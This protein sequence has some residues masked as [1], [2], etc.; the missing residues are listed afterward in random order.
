MTRIHLISATVGAI[1]LATGALAAREVA[2]VSMPDTDTIAGRAVVLNGMGVRRRMGVAVYVAGLHVEHASADAAAILSADEVRSMRLHLVRKVGGAR[3]AEA[4]VE[5][6]ERNSRADMPRPRERLAQ[7]V[8]MLPD[9]AAGDEI[10]LT[11]VPGTGT[12]VIVRGA[13]RGTIPG[14]DF[15]DALLAVWLGADPVQ[16]ELKRALLGR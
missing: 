8:A 11:C 3:M 14:R 15:A 9:V 12:L 4:I 5:G 7:F 1:A 10:V 16:A 6:F 13:L 2:G